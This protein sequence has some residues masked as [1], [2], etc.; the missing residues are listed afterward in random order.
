MLTNQMPMIVP[1]SPGDY[2]EPEFAEPYKAWSGNKTPEAATTL[3][4]AVHPVLTSAMRTYGGG[5]SPTLMS[6]AKV[7]ALDAMDRYDPSKAK[8]RTHLMFQLQGLRRMAAR[9]AQILAVPEQVGLD[10]KQ[11]REAENVLR[12]ELGRDPSD[13]EL[14]DHAKLSIRR[15]SH[16][17]KARPS[18]SEGSMQRA[19]DEGE[20]I[21]S[22]AVRQRYGKG[23]AK[24]WLKFVYNEL[25]PQDQLIMEHSFGMHG[26]PMLSNQ[27]I[28]RKL[29]VTPGAVSQRRAKIQ[30]KIDLRDDLDVL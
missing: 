3:L 28:A 8:L 29:R 15:I 1:N 13:S 7:I 6:R 23:Q 18:F 21:Y 27:D 9:E 30:Q 24:H 12:D 19:T 11:L 22:P 17:R 25:G 26:K 10:L 5:N 4:K 20:S 14:A 16:I 2:L